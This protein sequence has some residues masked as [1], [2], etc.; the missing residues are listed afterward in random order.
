MAAVDR[1][2]IFFE[3]LEAEPPSGRP[4]PIHP[5]DPEDYARRSESGF[6]VLE[7][8]GARETLPPPALHPASLPPPPRTPTTVRL[9]ASL[10][11]RLADWARRLEILTSTLHL[12]VLGRE[13][14][15]RVVRTQLEELEA[16]AR[17]ANVESLRV[18]ALRL[19]D[20][21]EELGG[22]AG[23]LPRLGREAMILGPDAEDAA[24]IALALE[25]NGHSA[26]VATT[27]ADLAR[28]L[29][30]GKS[31]LVFVAVDFPGAE[32]GQPFCRFVRELVGGTSVSVAVYGRGSEQRLSAIAEQAEADAVLRVDLGLEA[33]MIVVGDLVERIDG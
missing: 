26:R 9:P 6:H 13:R 28:L 12:G 18:L 2:A 16:A 24:C 4:T 27:A 33:L 32:P 5:F 15:A 25:A 10:P 8:D 1:S 3:P 11:T 7:D 21:I 22:I 23:E 17:G 29:A 14:A 19:R 20:M 31:D 30:E